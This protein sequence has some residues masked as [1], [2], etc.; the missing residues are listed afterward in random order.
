MRG[1]FMKIAISYR[2]EG[3][4]KGAFFDHFT[5]RAMTGVE[6]VIVAQ[7]NQATTSFANLV[8]Y[9]NGHNQYGLPL[10]TNIPQTTTDAKESGFIFIPGYTRDSDNKQPT[11]H[12]QRLTFENELIAKARLRGQ[13]VLAVCAGSWTLWQNYNGTV[14]EVVDHNYGGAMPRMSSAKPQVCNNKMIHQVVPKAGTYLAGAI[15]SCHAFPVNSVHWKAPDAPSASVS[16]LLEVSA[17]AQQDDHLAP[18]SRQ[19]HQMK[20]EPS[21]EAFETRFGV[22]MIG[23]QWHPEAFNPEEEDSSS[24]QAI[25]SFMVASG[26]TYLN[27]G[28]LNQEFS[29]LV[30]KCKGTFFAQGKVSSEFSKPEELSSMGL[31]T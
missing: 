21:I 5:L 3:N 16:S 17:S 28:K 31:K 25:F 22:P 4:G 27:R 12:T 14:K 18:Q 23:A 24:H 30:S 20:P 13:P 9:R 26:R 10:N 1:L 11:S 7:Q 19:Q 2:D 8:N 6:T 29:A 15:K